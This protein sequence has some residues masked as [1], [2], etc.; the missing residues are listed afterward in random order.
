MAIIASVR[1][2]FPPEARASRAS[3]A[4]RPNEVLRRALNGEPLGVAL[5]I[6]Q[7]EKIVGAKAGDHERALTVSLDKATGAARDIFQGR[8]LFNNDKRPG[9]DL[10]HLTA[11]SHRREKQREA[12]DFCSSLPLG[13]ARNT[14]A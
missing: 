14:L 8:R 2:G 1:P 5:V 10:V 13:G 3:A 11:R 6:A 9:V 4:V 7:L 12:V